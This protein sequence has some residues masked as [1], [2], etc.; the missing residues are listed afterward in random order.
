MTLNELDQ[1]DLKEYKRRVCDLI[2]EKNE[3]LT[4]CEAAAEALREYHD[5]GTLPFVLEA[6]NKARNA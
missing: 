6:I 2:I 3:L 4:A 1:R 5:D